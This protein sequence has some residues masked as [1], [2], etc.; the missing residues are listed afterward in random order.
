MNDVLERPQEWQELKRI[1]TEFRDFALSILLLHHGRAVIRM[2]FFDSSL[3][4]NRFFGSMFFSSKLTLLCRGA[5]LWSLVFSVHGGYAGIING[6]K[7]KEDSRLYM[8][9][10]QQVKRHACGG[11]LVD[12]YF[13]MT[14]A[15]CIYKE[16]NVVAGVT[17]VVGDHNIRKQT[18]GSRKEVKYFYIHPKYNPKTLENDIALLQ[19]AGGLQTSKS[20]NWIALPDKVTNIKAALV[21]SVAGWGATKTNGR[22]NVD[23]LET[24]VIIVPRQ[25]CKKKW[26]KLSKEVVCASGD[27]GFCQG[28]SGGPLVCNGK[29]EGIVSFNEKNNC[30]KPTKPNVYTRVSAY[31]PW[32]NNILKNPKNCEDPKSNS[33][34]LELVDAMGSAAMLWLVAS[35]QLLLDISGAYG[36][37][38]GIINGTEVDN[39]SRPYIVSVQ[40]G[41]THWCGGFLVQESFVMT[42]AHCIQWGVELTAV[43]GIHNI[44]NPKA[45]VPVKFY[46]IHP[47]YNNKTL[48]NDIAL[49]QLEGELK[50][51]KSVNW[52][53]L[54]KKDTDVK[55]KSRC[56]VAGWGRTTTKGAANNVLLEV[57]VDIVKR[58]KCKAYWG[59]LPKGTVC[60]STGFCQGDSGGP[61]VCNGKA[62]GIVS[63]NEKNNCDKPTKPNVYTRVSAHLPW[64]N[65]ILKSFKN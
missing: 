48:D 50:R 19:L 27:S 35:L 26:K 7:V 5:T 24:N 11:F 10:V 30:D 12:K 8:V 49:L 33:K 42:A 21:C 17:V 45:R 22:E 52:I 18:P 4:G 37:Y 41:K 51:S 60:G 39:G 63:Y 13:V 64:I 62:E 40:K 61:L 55:A 32:I 2:H 43:V 28:D 6:T 56:T 65:G 14:A 9:S 16:V 25:E 20:V 31:L 36:V 1:T 58:E 54:P 59:N 53:A 29:A 3:F 23:L 46:H 47:G 15:H 44:K 34:S 38:V 57:K